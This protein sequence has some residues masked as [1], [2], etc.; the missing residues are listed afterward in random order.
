MWKGIS[1]EDWLHSI[2]S[3][4]WGEGIVIVVVIIDISIEAF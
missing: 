1:E 2:T 3:S 4:H